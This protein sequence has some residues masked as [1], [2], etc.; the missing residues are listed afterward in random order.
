[1]TNKFIKKKRIF[2]KIHGTI[3]KPRLSIF[4]S[5]NHLYAQIINDIEQKTCT[6]Y[7]TLNFKKEKTEK[8]NVN[9]QSS[10]NVGF[11][12]SEKMLKKNIKKIVFDK[13]GRKYHGN[14]KVLADT[15]RENG[16]EF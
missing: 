8:I 1:M 7:S 16:I 9:S 6:S 14:I 2:K 10:K 4:R 5:N 11:I 12:L 3:E 15:L 13:N